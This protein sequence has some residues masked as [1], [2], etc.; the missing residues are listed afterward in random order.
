MPNL[1]E[2]HAVVAAVAPINGV[3]VGSW[4]D[5]ATWVI[6]FQSTATAPQKVAA[7]AVVAAYDPAAIPVPVQVTNYQGR[8]ALINAGLFN[9]V[10]GI[11]AASTDL[12]LKNAWDYAPNLLRDSPFIASLK[13]AAS[14]TDAQIDELFTAAA[15]I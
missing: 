2:L 15:A 11:V 5:R 14:L 13:S 8:Q 4:E 7:A 12:N 10:D 1:F 3:C 9:V 6:D